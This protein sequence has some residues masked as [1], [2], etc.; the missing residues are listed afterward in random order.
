MWPINKKKNNFVYWENKK[1]NKKKKSM[2]VNNILK[3]LI[4]LCTFTVVFTVEM[5]I[6]YMLMVQDS[7]PFH[8]PSGSEKHL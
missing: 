8:T 7:T 1:N 3:A 5:W 6:I 4:F 2:E